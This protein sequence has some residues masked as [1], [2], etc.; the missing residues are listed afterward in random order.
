MTSLFNVACPDLDLFGVIVI[1][2]QKKLGVEDRVS[3][4]GSAAARP[5]KEDH[6][7]S[8]IRSSH[9]YRYMYSLSKYRQ[10]YS[11]SQFVCQDTY[12]WYC[13]PAIPFF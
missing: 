13:I 7:Q 9:W 11:A 10:I 5:Q 1:E 6:L 3:L 2:W 12:F 4:I 8:K